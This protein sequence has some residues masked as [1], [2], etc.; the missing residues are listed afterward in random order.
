MV[1]SDVVPSDFVSLYLRQYYLSYQGLPRM[2]V[3]EIDLTDA[4]NVYVDE[5]EKHNNF[6]HMQKNTLLFRF[7]VDYYTILWTHKRLLC[8]MDGSYDV[9]GY[10]IEDI[11]LDHLNEFITSNSIPFGYPGLTARETLE[12]LSINGAIDKVLEAIIKAF[13]DNGITWDYSTGENSVQYLP[14]KWTM[15]RT[16]PASFKSLDL[17]E[18]RRTFKYEMS[19]SVIVAAIP[20]D[21]LISIGPVELE[22]TI[23]NCLEPCTYD[24]TELGGPDE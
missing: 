10:N 24:E 5:I 17:G 22:R 8:Y 23:T 19:I 20:M 1:I 2:G 12:Q 18:Y 11:E 3:A 6:L 7:F 21:D 15:A 14:I 4:Y 9:Y 16:D 13:K